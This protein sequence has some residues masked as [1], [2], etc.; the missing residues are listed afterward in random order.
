M[1]AGCDPLLPRASRL[2]PDDPRLL[3]W[4]ALCCLLAGLQRAGGPARLDLRV[5]SEGR[6]GH[7][8]LDDPVH[9]RTV[10]SVSAGTRD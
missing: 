3:A 9:A 5:W 6:L 2:V 4:R 7:V 1:A 8:A 10:C